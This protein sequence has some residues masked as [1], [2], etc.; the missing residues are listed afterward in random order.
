MSCLWKSAAVSGS[1]PGSQL[2]EWIFLAAS[3]Y[4]DPHGDPLATLSWAVML[5]PWIFLTLVSQSLGI[6][7]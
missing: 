7:C 3:V 5:G 1:D 6:S 4:G 2:V